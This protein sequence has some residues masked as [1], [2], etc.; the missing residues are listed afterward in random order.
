MNSKEPTE[1]ISLSSGPSENFAIVYGPR[2]SN[3]Y[4]C[5]YL[6]NSIE[7]NCIDC[8]SKDYDKAGDTAFKKVRIDVH[9]LTIIGEF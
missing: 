5:P 4:S 7:S 6:S 9:N 3:P 1:Y 8:V 2:L